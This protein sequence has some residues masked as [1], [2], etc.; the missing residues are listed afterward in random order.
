MQPVAQANYDPKSNN[1]RHSQADQE[2]CGVVGWLRQII[3]KS[4][5]HPKLASRLHKLI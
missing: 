3:E 5:A 1:I 2:F 4:R